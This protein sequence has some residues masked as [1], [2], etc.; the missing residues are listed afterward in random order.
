MHDF[1]DRELASRYTG[2]WR[3]TEGTILKPEGSI[4]LATGDGAIRRIIFREIPREDGAR[5]ELAVACA[6]ARFRGEVACQCQ[7][8]R[9][10]SRR[11]S[12]PQRGSRRAPVF[13]TG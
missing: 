9:R 2:P 4:R 8:I 7:P 12:N 13:R 10:R 6:V 3:K 11:E 5:V 1:A